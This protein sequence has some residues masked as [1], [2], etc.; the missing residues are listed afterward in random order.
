MLNIFDKLPCGFWCGYSCKCDGD[1]WWGCFYCFC[2]CPCK[3]ITITKYWSCR[4]QNWTTKAGWKVYT[5][6]KNLNRLIY[7]EMRKSYFLNN[8]TNCQLNWFC[9]NWCIATKSYS[10]NK[11]L[12]MIHDKV[13]ELKILRLRVVEIRMKFAAAGYADPRTWFLQPK[14]FSDCSCGI[15]CELIFRILKFFW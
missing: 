1:D 15:S 14:I 11:T 9:H 8:L 6:L 3:N 2:C 4:S 12:N 7:R 10:L 5:C 13:I